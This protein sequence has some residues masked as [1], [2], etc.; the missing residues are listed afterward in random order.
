MASSSSAAR[1]VSALPTE[2]PLLLIGSGLANLTLARALTEAGKGSPSHLRLFEQFQA[3]SHPHYSLN[4]H[5]YASAPLEKA[6]KS[7]GLIDGAT[8]DY[9][10][11]GRGRIESNAFDLETGAVLAPLDLPKGR[12]AHVNRAR[13]GAVIA[14]NKLAVEH[15]KKFERWEL[16]CDPDGREAVRVVFA[17]GTE[18]VGCAIIGGDGVHSAGASGSSTLGCLTTLR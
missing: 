11:G 2:L 8:V 17:D 9:P 14:G 18:A 15:G 3:T 12:T 10:L 4:L 5:Q 16:V 13:L 6:L 1:L 7:P